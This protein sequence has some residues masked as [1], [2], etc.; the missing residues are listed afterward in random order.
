MLGN[1]IDSLSANRLR[2]TS[3]ED[4][5]DD[6]IET[7]T[8]RVPVLDE[9]RIQ[10][11]H[12]DFRVVVNARLYGEDLIWNRPVTANATQIVCKVPF[13]GDTEHFRYR[14]RSADLDRPC[15]EIRD[16]ELVFRYVVLPDESVDL[17][18]EFEHDLK[19]LRLYL[20]WVR[21]SI[22]SF[23]S[24]IRSRAGELIR[25]RRQKLRNDRHLAEELGFPARRVASVVA[26]DLTVEEPPD[27]VDAPSSASSRAGSREH[28]AESGTFVHSPCYTSVRWNGEEFH[29][30]PNQASVIRL[31]HESYQQGVGEMSQHL[32]LT[33]IESKSR[34]LRDV[35]R[36]SGAW[37]TLVVHGE[38]KGTFRLNM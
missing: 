29:F 34:R 4:L 3:I 28:I 7:H 26:S 13:K 24:S 32:L 35:L 21:H 36:R 9:S 17:R 2:N 18:S 8:V 10:V 16:G 11:T 15:A 1:A 22:E 25:A 19:N 20:A 5:C 38:R 14:P 12:G 6:L 27:V 30:S 33:E 31:L 23:N 37:G